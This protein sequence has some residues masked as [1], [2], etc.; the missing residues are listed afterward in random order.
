MGLLSALGLTAP[1]AGQQAAHGDAAGSRDAKEAALE[2]WRS[3]RL[4]AVTMLRALASEAAAEKDSESAKAVLETNAVIK[5]L[6]GDPASAQQVQE[7]KRWLADDDVVA[8]VCAMDRDIRQPLLAALAS[9]EA[10]LSAS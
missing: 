3:V 10:S 9:V 1:K 2:K 5:Q 6:S 7:L 8:D 4:D